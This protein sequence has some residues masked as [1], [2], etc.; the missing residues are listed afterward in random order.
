VIDAVLEAV[1]KGKITN[2]VVYNRLAPALLPELKKLAS[3]A[4]KKSRLH[5]WLTQ[6]LGHPKLREHL[7]SI[8]TIMKLS[9]TP[10]DFRA[11][12]DQIHPRHG[13]TAQLDFDAPA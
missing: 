10:A 8:V 13:D 12:V 5:Q 4:E 2:E 3:K 7:P 1:A 9:K 11:N 6:E